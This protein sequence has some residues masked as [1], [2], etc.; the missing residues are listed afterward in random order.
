MDAIPSLSLL[1]RLLSEPPDLGIIADAGAWR[2]VRENAGR[3]G[4]HPLVASIARPHV[5]ATGRAWCD[6][7]LSSSWARHSSYL[8]QLD[9]IAAILEQAG[10]QALALKGPVLA[11]RFY[12]PPF[13][14]KPPTDLDLAVKKEDLDRTCDML[15]KLGYSLEASIR[16]KKLVNHHVKLNHPSRARIELHFRL[17]HK[18][19]GIP[20]G[21]FLERSADYQLPGGRTV[22]ILSPADELLHL[23]LHSVSGRFATLFHLYEVRKIWQLASPEIRRDAVRTA[24]RH[25]FTGAF[26]MTDLAFRARWSDAMITR[27]TPLEP[28]WLHWRLNPRLYSQY[29]RC[30]DPGRDLPLKVRLERKW[31]DFQ[32]T[33]RPLDGLKLGADMMLIAW[34]QLF[35]QGWRT[36]RVK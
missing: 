13:L 35:R 7:V 28:T 33:D 24:A 19:L 15:S 6:R 23:V 11:N 27:D 12:R 17:S 32:M 31:V 14:R 25:H 3:H 22:R 1:T 5:D 36:V 21:E 26:A 9:E 4:V 30:T 18:G 34:F 10:I 16:E 20:I 29:E 8:Q 2:I